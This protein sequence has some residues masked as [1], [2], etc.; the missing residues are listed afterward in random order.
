MAQRLSTGFFAF[1]L[2]TSVLG[3]S[4]SFF[5]ENRGQWPAQVSHRAELRGVT[6]WSERGAI[7]LDSYDHSAV[8]DR[9]AY[10]A[11]LTSTPPSP[12]TKHHVLR[13]EFV[14]AGMPV[15]CE[16]LG[17][18]RGAYNYILGNDRSKW[19]SG[20]HAF[21]AVLQHDVWPGIDVRVRGEHSAM[22]YDVLIAPG[23]DPSRI[24]L[25][26][27]GA[28]G[29]TLRAN[30]LVVRTSLGDLVESI[31]LA[32][33]E[34]NGE[35]RAVPCD[36]LLKNG[37]VGFTL[38]AYDRMLP[39]VIDPTLMF[40]TFSGSEA[41]NFGYTATFDN[42][43]YLY[44]GSTAFG[45]DYPLTTGAYQTTHAGGD[46]LFD[47][48]DV[49]LTKYD[50]T[51]TYLIW[52]TFYG[53]SSDELPHS[54]VVNGNDELFVLGTTSSANLP[55]ADGAFDSSFNGGPAV[56]LTNGLGADF[57]NGSDIFLARFRSDGGDLLASTFIGGTGT[58]GLNTAAGL[59]FNYADEVRGEIELD[60]NDN[61][62]VV[63]CTGSNNF[64]V[65]TDAYRTTFQGGS[66][67]GIALKIDASLGTLFWSTYFGGEAA[68]AVYSLDRDDEQNL[69]IT[70]GTRSANLPFTTGLHNDPLGGSADGYVARLSADGSALLH[71]T[72]CGSSQYD[73]TYFVEHDEEGH[74]FLFGQTGA[75]NGQLVFN[76]PYNVPNAGQFISKLTP[77]LDQVLMSSRFGQGDGEPDISPV[78]FLVDYCDKIYISGWGSTIFGSL[79]TTGLPVTSDAFQNTTTGNDFY[80]AVFDINMS[81]LFYA[82]YFGGDTSAE[83]VD[84]GTSRF[85]RRGR[86]YESVCAGC[87]G[88]SDFP[89]TPGAW[90]ATNE[91]GLC[92]NGVF[93]FDFD[94][95][96]VVADFSVDL[97]CLPA[98]I[99]FTNESYGG[100]GYVWDFGDGTG[101][102]ATSP[103]HVYDEPG[104]Y[105][106]MLVALNAAACNV[107]DT[108]YQQ[109]VVLGNEAYALN[110]TL[111]CA[112]TSVQI[113]VL[114]VQDPNITY[115]W[116]PATWLS[117]PNVANPIATP[118]VTTT[119]TLLISNG[120]CTDTITQV[121]EVQT[122]AIDAGPSV[123]VCGPS[124]T[125]TLTAN[126]F[127]NTEQF[128]WSSS[129]AFSNTLNSPPED[130][131]LNVTITGDAWYFVRGIGS[132]C[133]TYD[134][135][136]VDME[137]IAPALTGD[138]E[139][140]ADDT[141]HLFLIG[142]EAG[143]SIV[144][145]PDSEVD[146]GQGTAHVT[147]TPPDGQVFDVHVESPFGCIWDGSIMVSV[148]PL[149]GSTVGASVD[150]SIVLSGTTVHLT[151]TPSTGVD[152][153]WTPTA[154]VSDPTISSPTAFVTAST[155]FVVTITDGICT[156]NDSVYVKVYEL[157]CGE[158]DIFI[159]DAFTPNTDGQND[160][161]YVRG[162][163]IGAM[164]LKIF[165][166]WGE[167]VFETTDQKTGWDA[168]YKGKAVDPA[169]F[170]Y[171]LEATCLD[172]QQFFKKGNVTVI[173]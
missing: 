154:A 116:Q 168:T 57:P 111:V 23:A 114:P 163:H 140:C 32:Y 14:D 46:G 128:Q 94:F 101:S 45:Q 60:A 40:S 9:H 42:D 109:V 4:R 88:N 144:W 56:D 65:T 148:S 13:L 129:P 24:A 122:G 43:G 138:E 108:T 69:Y 59:K 10:H 147:T 16:G 70:G 91:S 123:T 171:W 107:S 1:A 35:R 152:Y 28:E 173:R 99:Q 54:L 71:G 115:S 31:P 142:V 151:A 48:I 8:A 146:S 47:G 84:G 25:R 82:T 72:Y 119:Y 87:G 39:L 150:Q 83:H 110:D 113:G 161:L 139:I 137:L 143:S 172:G 170:V 157:T 63:S 41:D 136:F 103:S 118:P 92:N 159:P 85:D 98:P 67:D 124:A 50:T 86:I 104:V 125:T 112:G 126:G 106:V 49:A 11:G 37:V 12:I 132:P 153:I 120:L 164:E 61:V 102:T 20:A 2:C 21:S 27:A 135:V 156:R 26:Y 117:N 7:T 121:V 38:G 90:S 80:L 64:P 162:Q 6:V 133:A 166:R 29:I 33:Q 79:S 73:Q 81:A 165:D 58:D 78:A 77:E 52:S 34:V 15:R 127:G 62:Y 17:V 131:T 3:Q 51:G 145:S 44:S 74:V 96:M 76:A 160:L 68:D 18:Q 105:T 169:V 75:P 141:A 30:E 167:L 19:A 155:W 36:Y 55:M 134:S 158:P 93:K 95:P 97:F 89:T 22:K 66:Q 130:S 53:G 5:I 149:F 100:S